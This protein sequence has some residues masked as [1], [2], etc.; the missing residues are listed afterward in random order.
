MEGQG[1]RATYACET[2]VSTDQAAPP[3]YLSRFCDM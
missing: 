1:E 3:P 2:G